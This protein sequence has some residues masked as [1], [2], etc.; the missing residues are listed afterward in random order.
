[1][2]TNIQR[3]RYPLK[4]NGARA[5]IFTTNGAQRKANARATRR[6]GR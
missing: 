1:M 5:M 6:I 3:K 4:A 2:G